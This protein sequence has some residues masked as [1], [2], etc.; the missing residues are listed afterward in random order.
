MYSYIWKYIGS[1]GNIW[2]KTLIGK[3]AS[4]S[5]GSFNPSIT[6]K[7]FG[8]ATRYDFYCLHNVPNTMFT[9]IKNIIFRI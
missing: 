9:K 6:L 1:K 2:E 4:N 3:T 7:T 5:P 8:A